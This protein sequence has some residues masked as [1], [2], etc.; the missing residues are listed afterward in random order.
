[1]LLVK[2]LVKLTLQ[3]TIILS[4]TQGSQ[5]KRESQAALFAKFLDISVTNSIHQ[6][7]KWENER[8]CEQERLKRKRIW[9]CQVTMYMYLLL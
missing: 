7:E 4:L 8:V 3:T 2:I 5:Q 9:K 1:M 6:E